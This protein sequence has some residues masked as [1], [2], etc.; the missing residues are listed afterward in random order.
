MK[1]CPYCHE[2]LNDDFTKY[3]YAYQGSERYPNYLVESYDVNCP[4]CGETIIWNEIF[5][6][7]SAELKKV[8]RYR[9]D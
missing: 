7:E 3:D 2:E 8:S 9:Y 4:H 6:F 5:W 1:S